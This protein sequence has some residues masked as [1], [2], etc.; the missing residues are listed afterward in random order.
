MRDDSEDV[1]LVLNGITPIYLYDRVLE[2]R[3]CAN[4]VFKSSVT[5][6]S[7]SCLS[8]SASSVACVRNLSPS[9]LCNSASS[10]SLA[11]LN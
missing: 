6:A 7:T 3:L 8:I 10:S 11:C 2:K 9:C 5:T 1:V 4:I